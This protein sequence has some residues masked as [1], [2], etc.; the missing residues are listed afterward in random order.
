MGTKA[1][2]GSVCYISINFMLKGHIGLHLSIPTKPSRRISQSRNFLIPVGHKT[3]N[4]IYPQIE[5]EADLF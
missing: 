2:T 3:W 4:W 1:D 5:S